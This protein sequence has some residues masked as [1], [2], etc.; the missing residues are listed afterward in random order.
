[1]KS[2]LTFGFTRSTNSSLLGERFEFVWPGHLTSP[3]PRQKLS[4]VFL[5]RNFQPSLGILHH[6]LVT[7]Y[8]VSPD[9]DTDIR[10]NSWFPVAASLNRRSTNTAA[11]VRLWLKNG[12][13]NMDNHSACPT[14]RGWACKRGH[15]CRHAMKMLTIKYDKENLGGSLKT[16]RWPHFLPITNRMTNA[17]SRVAFVSAFSSSL[18]FLMTWN[19][20]T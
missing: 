10:T 17:S 11:K 19:P 3:C 5:L 20:Q 12:K 2:T 16:E 6:L 9:S 13:K 7:L 4:L 18:E 8:C 14:G 1:M 15:W